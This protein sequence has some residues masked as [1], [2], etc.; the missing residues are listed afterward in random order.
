MCVRGS[1]R[2]QNAPPLHIASACH[3]RTG[4]HGT[5]DGLGHV[6]PPDGSEINAG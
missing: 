6:T 2:G 3:R 1:F 5:A 4:D